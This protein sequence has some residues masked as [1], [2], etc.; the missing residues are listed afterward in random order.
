MQDKIGVLTWYKAQQ[1]LLENDARLNGCTIANVDGFQGSEREIMILSTV[2][3]NTRGDIGFAKDGK[4]L[5]VALTRAQRGL[6]VVGN[7]HTLIAGDDEG[8]WTAWFQ[9]IPIMN[10]RGESL[11]VD[12]LE[13]EAVRPKVVKVETK[14]VVSH[15]VEKA[16]PWQRNLKWTD[17]GK[18]DAG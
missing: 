3:C 5:N 18:E 14:V 13:E 15:G 7:Y 10:A 11:R 17:V 16:A 1:E 9:N 2:R 12:E 6:I 4:R 8:L